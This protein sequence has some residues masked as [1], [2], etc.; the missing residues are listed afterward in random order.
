MKIVLLV[1][2]I[3]AGFQI[4]Y[5]L[6]FGPV[7]IKRPIQDCWDGNKCILDGHCGNQG[8]C[9]G[10]INIVTIPPKFVPGLAFT[11]KSINYHFKTNITF[12]PE[13]VNANI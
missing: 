9:I 6:A 11:D 10:A 7:G 12:I 1:T 13:L 5:N 4:Q 2:L 8:D 3:F